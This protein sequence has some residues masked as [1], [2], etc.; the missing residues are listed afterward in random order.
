MRLILGSLSAVA[1]LALL[2]SGWALLQDFKPKEP[3]VGAITSAT[4]VNTGSAR[5][6]DN[7]NAEALSDGEIEAD[8]PNDTDLSTEAVA[9]QSSDQ[10]VP[11][12]SEGQDALDGYSVAQGADQPDLEVVESES[13][14]KGDI[15]VSELAPNA[16]EVSENLGS[17]EEDLALLDD[18]QQLPAVPSSPSDGGVPPVPNSD[19]LA[20]IPEQPGGVP[21]SAT[22]D[23]TQDA[24]SEGTEPSVDESS[25]D[26]SDVQSTSPITRLPTIGDVGS[27]SNLIDRRR[28]NT[29]SNGGTTLPTIDSQ[30]DA[31]PG[32]TDIVNTPLYQFSSEVEITTL[33]KVGILLERDGQPDI[34]ISQ[35][36]LAVSFLISGPDRQNRTVYQ[37]A[38][39]SGHEVFSSISAEDTLAFT[40]PDQAESALTTLF[41]TFPEAIGYVQE[42]VVELEAG[43]KAAV[44]NTLQAQGRGYLEF[45]TGLQSGAFGA[46]EN[47]VP[48]GEIDLG[49]TGEISSETIGRAIERAAL[50]AAQSGSVILILPLQQA[51]IDELR[52]FEASSRGDTVAF[53][54]VSQV[55]LP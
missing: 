34:E 55:I 21:N 2:A 54:P 52:A 7:L 8:L 15:V 14:S 46:N 22:D 42:P 1:T 5:Q 35:I 16:P 18:A 28:N 50:Q 4:L 48:S 9:N 26:T 19:G 41:E 11:E 44:L 38:R 24:T 45:A 13:A 29:L 27:G 17:E 43:G 47:I 6:D 37:E 20:S 10:A 30:T 53:V 40:T 12:T 39:R 31:I 23:E 49:I 3:G 32:E 51:T 36:D 25:S 33:P